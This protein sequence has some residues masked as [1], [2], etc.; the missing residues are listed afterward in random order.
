MGYKNPLLD[1]P[2]GATLTALPARLRAPLEA[3]MRDLRHQANDEAE[4]AWGKRKGLMAAYWRAVS[5]YPRHTA[6]PLSKR[7]K[8][9]IPRS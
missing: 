2:A 3:L 5:T 4:K 1:L 6:H 7:K 8:P 9:W